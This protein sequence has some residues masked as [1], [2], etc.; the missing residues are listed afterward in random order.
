[1]RRNMANQRGTNPPN[2]DPNSAQRVSLA[3]KLRATRMTYESIAH[4]VGYANA[5][6][7]RKAILREL[8]RTICRDVEILRNEEADSLD[9]LEQE[10]WKRLYD[11]HY[12]KSMLFC[13]DRIVQI[14]ERRSRLLGLDVQKDA[15]IAANQ[16]IVRE[17]PSGYM[18]LH[19]SVQG[20]PT[21]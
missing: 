6:S 9:R 16:V 11:K 12:E 13:V 17:L 4:Q 5:S 2:R 3:L 8:D 7:C 14:K 10:C 1:M 19:E 15:T 18:S 20:E 21:V